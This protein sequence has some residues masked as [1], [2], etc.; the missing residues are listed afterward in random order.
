MIFILDAGHGGI[1][2]FGRYTTKG[3]SFTHAEGTFHR[4]KTFYEGVFNRRLTDIVF[5][6]LKEF[7]IPVVKVYHDY[8]DLDLSLRVYRANGFYNKFGDGVLISN[9]ANASH[10]HT[11]RGFEVFSGPGFS[12]SDKIADE[13]FRNVKDFLGDCIQYRPGGSTAGKEANFFLLRNFDGPAIL[14][15][16]LFF[17]NYDDAILLMDPIIIEKFA[18]AQV[19]TILDI[20]YDRRR[21]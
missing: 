21:I 13:Y 6:S 11:A 15:E 16:H 19:Q 18:Q 17:D 3:K 20:Y 8:L 5:D 1:D 12:Q 7:N 14:A 9:H 2:P 10:A 4:G